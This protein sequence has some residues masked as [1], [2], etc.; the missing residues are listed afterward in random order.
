MG[1][2]QQ[3]RAGDDV[4]PEAGDDLSNVRRD[5]GVDGT[6]RDVC[7]AGVDRGDASERRPG[8]W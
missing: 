4:D 5:H 6:D 8:D 7:D 2:D 3:Q 1:D